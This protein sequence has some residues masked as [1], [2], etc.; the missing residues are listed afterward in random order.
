MQWD[1]Q[2]LSL[3]FSGLSQN[4]RRMLPVPRARN[5]I[6]PSLQGPL[7]SFYLLHFPFYPKVTSIPFFTIFIFSIIAGLLCCVNFLLY[8]KVTQSHI[9]GYILFSHMIILHHKW[10]DR[11][12]L[13]YSRI[14]FLFHSKGNS[15]NYYSNTI[16]YLFLPLSLVSMEQR[17]KRFWLLPFKILVIG[18]VHVVYIDNFAFFISV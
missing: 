1:I 16:D 18:V 2:I 5:R 13:L 12:L 14:S 6:Y 11:V 10:L 8:S 3:Q 17:N 4:K 15:G 9:H 7:S